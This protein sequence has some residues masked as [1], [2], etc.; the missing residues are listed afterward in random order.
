MTDPLLYAIPAF[1]ALAGVEA[2]CLRAKKSPSAYRLADFVSG[3]ACG[4]LDQ[5]VNVV[6][7]IG[8]LVAYDTL[9]RDHGLF[10]LDA[11]SP[12]AWALAV[13]A[14]DLAYYGFH[15]ASHRV[16]ALWAAHVVHHQGED[17][18]FTISFRQGAVATWV[19]YVFY[20]PLAL[21]GVGVE[22]FVVVHG[23]YQIYQ[24]FVHTELCPRLGPLEWILATPRHHRLHH[25]RNDAYL[26]KN[27]GG[28]FIV[29]DRLFGTFAKETVPPEIGSR[30]GI[31]SW[32]PFWANTSAFHT[33]AAKAK[34]ARG[35]L[36]KARVWLG[37]PEATARL[38]GD[39]P[40]PRYDRAPPRPLRVYAV[41]LF[42]SAVVATLYV[43]LARAELATVALL[44][45]ALFV[46]VALA[47]VSAVFDG[48]LA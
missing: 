31:Q 10:A 41:A 6:P 26:D 45:L 12:W 24:F 35:A 14:H 33:L 5:I 16:S 11:S 8:L 1:L 28:F 30:A 22:M 40:I 9:A 3:L 7:M 27:Y 23:A 19:S 46:L 37:P 20:L 34:K 13:L 48:K 4:V 29:W 17:Y 39:A 47:A 2:A 15:R 44:A 21:V 36:A 32:S 38:D 18:N 25:G 43:L 42:G